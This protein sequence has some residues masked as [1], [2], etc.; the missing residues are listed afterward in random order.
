MNEVA[1]IDF[2]QEAS[3]TWTNGGWLMVPLLLLAMFIYYTALDLYLRLQT[4]FILKSKLHKMSDVEVSQKL[5]QPDSLID[6][7]IHHD[8][9]SPREVQSHFTEVRNEY[10]PI[11]N[12][13][14]RFLSIIITTGPLLGLLGTV[15]GM[16]ST[17]QGMQRGSGNKFSE[18]V[19]GISEA[20]ITTQTGLIISIPA[21]VILSLIIQKRNAL[22]HSIAK[23]E[24][25][26]TRL[27]IQTN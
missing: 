22:E 12:R 4:H 3:N 27:A 18:I 1:S 16:L 15:T 14:I 11:I 9:Q 10:L 7:L 6:Q 20:L 17:F 13:R 2:F 5:Q 19:G 23:L 25:Y 8:A 26:N 24:S 21:F